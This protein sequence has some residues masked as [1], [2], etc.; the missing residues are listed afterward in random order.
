MLTV[1]QA[2]Y[3]LRRVPP[4][5]LP[6]VVGRYAWQT[7]RARARRWQMVRNRG[8]LSD[9]AL[10]RALGHTSA[11]AAFAG[12]LERFF[13]RPADARER[14]HTIA[15][16]Y[17]QHARRTLEAAERA[18]DHVVDLLGSG[19][20]PLGQRINWQRDFV[21][22]FTW[23]NALLPDQQDTLRLDDPCDIKRPWEL[24]RCHHWVAL[25]RAYACE[26]DPRYASEFVSQF[27]AWLEDNP[28][29][30]GVNWSRAMEVA[31][32]AVNWLW[33][34]ALFAEAP[35]FTPALKR[36][37][38]KAMLQHGDFIINNLEYTDNNGNHY[39]SNGVGLL[40][41]GVLFPEL[42]PAS[43]WRK[44]GGEIVWGEIQR[45]VHPDGVDF[46]QAIGYHGLVSE[47]WYSCVLLC[48]RNRIEVPAHVRPRLERMFDFMLAY[49]RPDGTFP[50]VGDN[51]DGRLAGIDDVPVGSHQRHLAVGGVLFGRPDLLG[52]AGSALETAVWL[53]GPSVTSMPRTE[54]AQES[55]AFVNGGFY[56]MRCADASMVIDAGEVGMR[57]IG[58]H[59]HN[60][61]LSFDLWAAGAGVLVDSGTY[62]YSADALARQA[63][64]GTSAH[65]A[66]RIDAHETSRL[67]TGRWLWLIEN[68]AHPFGISWSSDPERDEFAG[69]HDGYRR[70]SD[71][72][73]HT[74][75]VR[76]LKNRL[77]WRIEDHIKGTGAHLV[78]LF[79]HPGVEFDVEEDDAVRLKAKRGDVWLFPPKHALF[80]QDEGW[81]SKGYGLR[82]PAPVL[83]Y[84]VNGR[85]PM[86]LRTDL[87]LVPSGTP[88]S[89]ARCLVEPD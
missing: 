55:K 68:D 31:V 87:V 8:E 26:A 74:R 64:R 21:T 35:E 32:R 27:Q 4:R 18:L 85:T 54:S 13:V 40:F 89:A 15:T 23:S 41:L 46:E 83:V 51:D 59:G 79:F 30:Y 42:A 78:Q 24:S 7:A 1:G 22:G 34:A 65:N 72:V 69:S 52:A 43:A 82:V 3:R 77:S 14:A 67:G 6:V 11:E 12:F 75:R 44:K 29:P 48:E 10:A 66:V 9:A 38:L 45:Q 88:A 84:A 53:C 19:P 62:T 86:R 28:W 33:A 5:R 47:F 73:I 70:L 37:F 60:D 2:V 76:F 17:P 58:G 63:M 49:T 20:V 81:I 80:R 25:G 36:R 56:I 71:G 50:Q 61:V 39:L 16:T 57:G